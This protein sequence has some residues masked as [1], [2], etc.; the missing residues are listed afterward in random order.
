[1]TNLPEALR[2]KLDGGF[3]L[4]VPELMKKQISGRDG[5]TKYLWRMAGGA[6][7]ES[8]VM[9]YRHGNTICISTQAGCAM[10]CAFCASTIGGLERNL[11]AS[12]ME[13]Q[14]MFSELDCGKRI[15]N[16][17]LMGIGEPLDN[18]DNVMRFLQLVT[19]P[20]GM[21][22]GARHI[23]LSTCGI[24][25][26]IDKMAQCGIQLTMTVSLHAPD[27]ETRSLLMPVSRNNG[28]DDLLDACRRYFRE[29]GRRISF[30]YAMIHG[31]NDS[32]SHAGLLAKK[33]INS[34]SHL[35]LI[36]LND[37]P[38]RDFTASSPENF[39][40]F[41]QIL[42]RNGINYTVRR[43]LGGDIDAA[44]GQLRRRSL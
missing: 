6:S 34:E 24:I 26:N 32:A 9:E 33:L 16:I 5:T 1:M 12:E 42:K 21:N 40:A 3:T 7:I 20:E 10:G 28:V 43:R 37:I 17:V 22:I 8:V 44:C 13:D 25:E 4:N 31:V 35:N 23:T 29:T 36:M 27:D 15:S 14:V 2:N 11:S 38:G 30:E 39:S 41:T 18:F 19:H